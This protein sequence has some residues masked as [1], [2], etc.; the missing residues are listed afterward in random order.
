[1]SQS[2]KTSENSPQN[3]LPQTES[4][5]ST[6][7]VEGSRAKT[8]ASRARARALKA[9]GLVCGKNFTGSFAKYDPA[10]QSWKTLLPSV[11][12][13]S[14]LCSR[15]WPRSGTMRNGIV[16][17][18]QPL[19]PLTRG[20]DSGSWST[21]CGTTQRPNEGNVR[22]LRQQVQKGN[23]TEAEATAWLG[24]SPF[25]AQG[26]LPAMLPT[27]NY[28][29]ATRKRSIKADRLPDVLG[30]LPNPQ[31][32]EWIMGYPMEWTAVKPSETP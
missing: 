30:G 32:Q 22:L 4:D 3:N 28:R 17:Q 15:T 31:F 9:K 18:H 21:P 7:S 13:D 23:V 8:S 16:Y 14:T 29:D 25:C 24:K 10:T 2:T 6:L 1:M 20:T 12:A 11:V 27:P 19:A 5:P 26:K